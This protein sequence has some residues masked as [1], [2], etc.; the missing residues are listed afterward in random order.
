MDTA[1]KIFYTIGAAIGF[2]LVPF[3]VYL[4]YASWKG[5]NELFREMDEEIRKRGG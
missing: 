3:C 2:L 4:V 1:I 5:W